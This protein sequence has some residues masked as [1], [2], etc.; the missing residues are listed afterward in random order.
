M[1]WCFL[2][3]F[4]WWFDVFWWSLMNVWYVLMEFW[5]IVDVCLMD[6]DELLMNVWCYLMVCNDFLMLLMVFD[7]F[8]MV[9]DIFWCFFMVLM[10]FW[11]V[12]QQ[13]WP[14]PL[15][16]WGSTWQSNW[17]VT[18]R[19]NQSGG[20]T[21]RNGC[22]RTCI[23][24]DHFLVSN[25]PKLRCK[26]FEP[27]PFGWKLKNDLLRDGDLLLAGIGDPEFPHGWWL[28]I[29]HHPLSMRHP[30]CGD[31]WVTVKIGKRTRP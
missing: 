10:V 7:E 9:F 19:T 31:W 3:E 12:C 24:V 2:M 20:W 23:I 26:I 5:W 25:H 17:D 6:L 18:N 4:S 13:T 14:F 30:W 16:R 29:Q 27:Q 8:L 11:N 22:Q 21:G 15:Q 1:F 28:L